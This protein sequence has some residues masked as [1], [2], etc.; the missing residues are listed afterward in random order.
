MSEEITH[1]P[2]AKIGKLSLPKSQSITRALNSVLTYVPL[3]PF[4]E[5]PKTQ[6]KEAASS[7]PHQSI[8][9]TFFSTARHDSLVKNGKS[10]GPPFGVPYQIPAGIPCTI[11]AEA[12][13]QASLG[14]LGVLDWD[15]Q[16]EL[17]L[18]HIPAYW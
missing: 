3:A 5:L 8:P 15:L 6:K 16:P 17:P 12:R 9:S 1:Q 4:K 14:F 13:V 18:R 10:S 7:I 2:G 11:R